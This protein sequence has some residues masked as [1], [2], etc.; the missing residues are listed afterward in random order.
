M[1]RSAGGS[2]S[3]SPS[4]SSSASSSATNSSSSTATT[5]SPSSSAPPPS[6]A[7][8]Q[9]QQ[10][11]QQQRKTVWTRPSVSGPAPSARCA[12]STTVVASNVFIFGG[13]DGNKM[14]NDLHMLHTDLVSSSTPSL[15]WSKPITTGI[16]PGPRAGH[17]VEA[18]DTK[19]Y[20]F[21]GGN[22][23]RYLNDLYTLDA[24]TMS[25]SQAYVAGTSPAARSRHT[26]TLVAGLDGTAKFVVMG[27]GD[28]TRVYNDVYVLD[29]GTMAWSRPVTKG[30]APVAR[31]GHTATLIGTNQIFIF[32]GHD[33]TRM[34]NDLFVLNTDTMTWQQIS[35]HGTVPSAR[36]G[37]TA[38]AIMDKIFIFGGGDGTRILNDLY[39][40]DPNTLTFTRPNI[41][42]MAP[43]ARCAHTATTLELKSLLFYGGGDG[44]RR[45]K[46]L[47]LL[48]AESVLRMEARTKEKQ[49]Q[50]KGQ[51]NRRND[52]P[53]DHLVNAK[54]LAQ[55]L[56]GLGMRQYVDNFTREEIT[57]E[58]VPLLTETHLEKLGVSTM[59]ARL[60]I[61]SA[62][63]ELKQYRQSKQ[64][65]KPDEARL[66]KAL[67]QINQNLQQITAGLEA[68]NKS[69]LTFAPFAGLLA[70]EEAEISESEHEDSDE[71]SSYLAHHSSS[72]YS[73][74]NHPSSP[75]Q[76]TQHYHNNNNNNN[77]PTHHNNMSG[78]TQ[79]PP[80]PS[81]SPSYQHYHHHLHHLPSSSSYPPYQPPPSSSSN[82]TT[83]MVGHRSP[84]PPSPASIVNAVAAAARA[85]SSSSCPSSSVTSPRGSP[86]SYEH[87]VPHQ[88]V[89]SN[90]SSPSSGSSS[91]A[92]SICNNGSCT[93]PQSHQQH[94]LHQHHQ[95]HQQQQQ[96]M[97]HHPQQQH[98]YQ[99]NS[100]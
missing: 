39:L 88:P 69:L 87:H 62:I 26:M 77:N 35:P 78:G 100:S 16:A 31:W 7:N 60:R 54:S 21:G 1:R 58:V 89:H 2:G 68:L 86:S 29:T 43:A 12:H 84:S 4:P 15:T 24:E 49:K 32:G 47:Y 79:H 98:Q 72:N 92:S 41:S 81:T 34:L 55:W 50:C 83:M 46:D 97:Q 38:T 56:N 61:L 91:S 17:T 90:T 80:P 14:L 22:G 73:D 57:L 37:H 8:Q 96:Q 99:E 52:K 51:H 9:P 85:S 70:Q 19:L 25:W 75:S 94:H 30:A 76:Q 3:S 93:H 67:K 42:H 5:A 18:V 23:V 53:Q 28:D 13:W 95:H 6:S 40:F 74:S 82:N 11:Q 59:G 36:A 45:F 10:Q 65:D 66:P 63:E 64:E 27:G 48:D 71:P 33:G 20:L 44:T